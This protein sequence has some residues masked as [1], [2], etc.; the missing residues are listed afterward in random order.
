MYIFKTLLTSRLSVFFQRL[1]KYFGHVPTI[2]LSFCYLKYVSLCEPNYLILIAEM[3]LYCDDIYCKLERHVWGSD[4]FIRGLSGKESLQLHQAER[5]CMW[6][7]F[8]YYF[9]SIWGWELKNLNLVYIFVYV[10][11]ESGLLIFFKII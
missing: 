9:C 4:F 6:L 3:V 1:T 11:Y 2:F 10:F 8:S 5:I 7:R